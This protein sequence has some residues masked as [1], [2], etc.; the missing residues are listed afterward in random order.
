M[1]VLIVDDTAEMRQALGELL[2]RRGH[3]VIA[4]VADG[5][6]ALEAASRLELDVILLDVLLGSGSGL[7]VARVLTSKH[8][9]IPVVLM[10]MNDVRAADLHASGARSVI[11]KERLA[12]ID[13]STLISG[14]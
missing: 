13:L 2:Q 1:K 4:S 9:D 5:D 12:R 6:E 7:D 11:A 14:I 10:S 8:P 3:D